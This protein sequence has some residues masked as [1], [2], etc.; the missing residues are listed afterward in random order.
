MT[1]TDPEGNELKQPC[2]FFT[3]LTVKDFDKPFFLTKTYNEQDYETYDNYD[4]IE[5]PK[6]DLI[7]K[8]YEG[9]MGVP[10]SF[11]KYY[12]ELDYEILEKKMDLKLNGKQLFIR[13]II[14]KK[15]N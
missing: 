11:M 4:A 5:V 6:L 12:P 15:T 9:K 7:P 10:T 8:D 2:M 13:L 3:T 1:M 14:K